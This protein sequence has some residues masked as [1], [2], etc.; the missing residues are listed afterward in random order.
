LILFQRANIIIELREF[1]MAVDELLEKRGMTRY[2][3]AV[4]TD[5]E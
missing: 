2:R 4:Q 5:I 3:L 1:V